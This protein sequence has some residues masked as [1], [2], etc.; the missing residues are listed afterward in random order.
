MSGYLDRRMQRTQQALDSLT[1]L[2]NKDSDNPSLR[3]R[4]EAAYNRLADAGLI[5]EDGELDHRR[6]N[7][8]EDHIHMSWSRES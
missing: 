1:Y 6:I 5:K 2:E 4:A 3:R 8:P 7:A